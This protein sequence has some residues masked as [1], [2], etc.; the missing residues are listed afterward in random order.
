MSAWDVF[1]SVWVGTW[2]TLKNK[3]LKDKDGKG[4]K[5]ASR[6]TDAG[7]DKLQKYYGNAIGANVGDVKAMERSCWAVFHHSCFD[8]GERQH[9]YCPVGP[10]TWCPYIHAIIRVEIFT[11]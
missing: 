5:F 2:V 1:R 9:E 4:P 8:D 6:L 3:V 10:N 7:I 11:C